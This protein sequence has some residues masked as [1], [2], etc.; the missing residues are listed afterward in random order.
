ML[1]HKGIIPI[2]ASTTFT[3][4]GQT[5]ALLG[6]SRHTIYKQTISADSCL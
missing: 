4:V 3:V 6:V 5:S 2:V 1:Q